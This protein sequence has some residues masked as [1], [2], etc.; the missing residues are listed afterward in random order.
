MGQRYV[1]PVAFVIAVPTLRDV[2]ANPAFR[3]HP[4]T[5]DRQGD[6]AITIHGR[7]RLTITHDELDDRIVIKEVSDHYDD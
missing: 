6:Y 2:Y 7:W 4:L 3:L 1:E 5:A